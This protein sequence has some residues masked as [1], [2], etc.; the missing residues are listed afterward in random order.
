MDVSDKI[1]TMARL[2]SLFY[3]SLTCIRDGEGF[4]FCHLLVPLNQPPCRCGEAGGLV[5]RSNKREYWLLACL[6]GPLV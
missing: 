5:K 1:D 2:P 4:C 3:P 6:F